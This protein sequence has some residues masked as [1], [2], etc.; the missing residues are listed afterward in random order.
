V[1]IT[2]SRLTHRAPPRPN[3]GAALQPGEPFAASA[4]NRELVPGSGLS[5]TSVAWGPGARFT[6]TSPGALI[7]DVERRHA[8]EAPIRRARGRAGVT[9]LYT[10]LVLMSATAPLLLF[11]AWIW[12]VDYTLGGGAILVALVA[13]VIGTAYSAA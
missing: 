6:F 1:T 7:A 9:V 11:T 13:G 12:A 2:N 8:R 10:L 4:D 5:C 3:L